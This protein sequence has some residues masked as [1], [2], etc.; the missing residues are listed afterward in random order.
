MRHRTFARL[1]PALAALLAA[2]IP[3]AAQDRWPERPL[4]LIVPY[5]PGGYTDAVGRL[6]GRYLERALGQ[7]VVVENRAGA[8]G[9]VG[10][11][12]TARAAPDGYTFCMCS[13]GAVSIAPVADR[14]NYDPVAD[15]GPISLVSAIPQMVIVNPAVPAQT[16]AELIAF[17]RA[18]P[19]R[20]NYAS[21]GVGGLMHFS[22]ELFLARTGV[23]MTHVPYRG[24]APATLAVVTGEAQL[25]FTNMTDALP[26][27]QAGTVRALAVTALE[28]SSFAPSVP[29]VIEA[30]LPGFSAES[31]NGMIGPAGLPEPIVRHLSGV[32]AEMARS[33]EVIAGM[34]AVGAVPVATTPE[35]F[36]A[37]IRAEL[38]Q[39][40][41]T[42]RQIRSR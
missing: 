18:N 32:L 14:V 25:T 13:V 41:E 8:G 31:W 1:W 42:L 4:R 9:I 23:H 12:A 33:P 37:R 36:A 34:A 16:L 10:T 24:G 38:E 3:A 40:R 26:Q 2:T 22:V 11:E 5:A 30:G 17:A 21:S 27:V 15:L 35:E 7:S 6:T 28:R 19:D 20:L 39:W 29:T